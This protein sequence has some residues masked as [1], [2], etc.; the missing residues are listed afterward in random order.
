MHRSSRVQLACRRIFRH[1]QPINRHEDASSAQADA[2]NRSGHQSSLSVGTPPR[3]RT[4]S[5]SATL[6]PT[7]SLRLAEAM[8]VATVLIELPSAY[9]I[10]LSE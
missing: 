6:D 8:W 7:A 10:S 3:V 2:L 1:S 9:A 4:L 5:M